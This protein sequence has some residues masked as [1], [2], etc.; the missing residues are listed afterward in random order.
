MSWPISA[1]FPA[2]RYAPHLQTR[3]DVYKNAATDSGG[4][5]CMLFLHGGGWSGGSRLDCLTPTHNGYSLLDYVIASGPTTKRWNVVSIDYR[6]FTYTNGIKNSYQSVFPDHYEDCAHAVQHVKD[7]ARLFGTNPDADARSY[8]I[9]PNKIV[10]FGFSAGGTM[11]LV[12]SLRRSAPYFNTTPWAPNRFI[13]RSSST[14]ALVVNMKGPID[15]RYNTVAGAE[16]FAYNQLPALFGTSTTD[17]PLGTEWG[18]V[19]PELKAAASPMAYLEQTVLEAQPA[20]VYSIYETTTPITPSQPWPNLH[21][22]RQEPI[23][24][25]ALLARGIP[26]QSEVI[27]T[28]EDNALNA[29]IVAFLEARL[30]A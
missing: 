11:A 15:V 7:N 29:R 10:L 1:D 12:N 13:Y 30:A 25:A 19:S 23:L 4:N 5:C 27:A 3:L 22:S 16:R 6:T 18:L 24:A 2:V 26:Y 8:G 28:V 14:P 9:N 21:D 20:G 17:S